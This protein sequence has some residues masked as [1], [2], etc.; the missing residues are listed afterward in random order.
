[1]HKF[2]LI[3]FINLSYVLDVS[4]KLDNY[5]M[6]SFVLVF[7][8]GFLTDSYFI[9]VIRF[10][11]RTFKKLT[12]FRR[13]KKNSPKLLLIFIKYPTSYLLKIEIRP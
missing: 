13:G 2:I 8:S 12:F 11:A 3:H 10:Q 6:L 9:P 7:S 5:S 4:K 1:M